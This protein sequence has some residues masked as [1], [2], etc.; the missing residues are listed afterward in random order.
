MV[1]V[2]ASTTHTRPLTPILSLGDPRTGGGE[3]CVLFAVSELNWS[4]MVRAWTV[5]GVR[6]QHLELASFMCSN[7]LL[8]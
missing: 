7:D 8:E 6:K 3:T 4:G 5:V 1:Q 2:C